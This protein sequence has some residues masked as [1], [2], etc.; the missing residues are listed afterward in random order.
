MPKFFV[1]LAHVNAHVVCLKATSHVEVYTGNSANLRGVV[2]YRAGS[3]DCFPVDT[4]VQ[5]DNLIPIPHPDIIEQHQTGTFR[6][7][8]QCP[9]EF[10]DQLVAA[11]RASDTLE[12]RQERRLNQLLGL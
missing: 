2:F 4:V 5:P 11:I 8:G 6:I 1:A 7:A 3:I 12:P 10:H 9:K